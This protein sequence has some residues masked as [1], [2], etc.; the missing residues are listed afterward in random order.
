L[1]IFNLW[2][3]N[4]HLPFHVS[5]KRLTMIYGFMFGEE[6]DGGISCNTPTTPLLFV[7]KV[8]VI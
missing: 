2:N 3:I 1:E 4:F 7:E 5:I 8:P 6:G